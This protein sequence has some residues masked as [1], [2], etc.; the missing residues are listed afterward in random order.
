MAPV[1]N[2]PPRNTAVPAGNTTQQTQQTTGTAETAATTATTAAQPARRG[3]SERVSDFLQTEGNRTAQR[4]NK[5]LN[6]SANL[7]IFEARAA[8]S[9]RALTERNDTDPFRRA[10]GKVWDQAIAEYLDTGLDAPDLQMVNSFKRRPFVQ[11]EMERLLGISG[12]DF[13]DFWSV[14]NRQRIA[15]AVDPLLQPRGPLLQV[16]PREG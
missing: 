4:D 14:A 13:R 6:T 5:I 15:E 1:N 11:R 10:S 12:G 16:Q 8:L 3:T 2:N 7:G 9:V